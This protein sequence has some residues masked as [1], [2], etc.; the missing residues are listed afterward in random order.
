MITFLLCVDGGIAES[1]PQKMKLQVFDFIQ[2]YLN[3]SE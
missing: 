3:Q 1:V 2:I